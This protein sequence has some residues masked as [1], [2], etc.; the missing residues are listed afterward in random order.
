MKSENFLKVN[1]MKDISDFFKDK[2]ILVTGGCGSIGASLVKQLINYN[3]KR[4]RAF[5]HNE[6][7]LFH[8]Q[9][10]T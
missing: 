8:L 9:E 3:V 4:V 1:E 2:D 6:S 7:G 5:D 10:S